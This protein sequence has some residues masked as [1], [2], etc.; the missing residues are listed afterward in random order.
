MSTAH[1]VFATKGAAEAVF[2]VHTAAP[3]AHIAVPADGGWVALQAEGDRW[4]RYQVYYRVYTGRPD[5]LY[6][7]GGWALIPR[8]ERPHLLPADA[9]E[10]LD[11]ALWRARGE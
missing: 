11:R 6:T 9:K 1:V 3:L 2:V 8:D 5:D 10:A 7:K 4:R